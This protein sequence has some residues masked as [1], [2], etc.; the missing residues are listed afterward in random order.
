MQ[1][2]HFIIL[3]V[4]FISTFFVFSCRE[5]DQ[6]IVHGHAFSYQDAEAIADVEVSLEV[7]KIQQAS[8]SGEWET[9]ENTRTSVDGSFEF[10]FE[11]MR[12]EKYRLTLTHDLFR[13]K[14]IDFEPKDLAAEYQFTET[15]VRDARLYLRLKNQIP[16]ISST[17]EIRVRVSDI[18]EDCDDCTVTDFM[19]FIGADIDTSLVYEL[20]G[21]DDVLIEYT[22][23]KSESDFTQS[24]QYIEPNV[25]NYRQINY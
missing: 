2:H 25:D 7:K 9:I 1:R 21:N 5:E 16:P 6:N 10:V 15:M 4:V 19:S 11:A 14:Q 23:I 24:W 20:A 17:D 22:V 3:I 8:Y 13:E 12:A 18:P